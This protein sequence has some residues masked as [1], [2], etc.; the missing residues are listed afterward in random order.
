MKNY[1]RQDQQDF[2][3]LMFSLFP[4]KRVKGNPLS[5][6]YKICSQ[7]A[8]ILFAFLQKKQKILPIL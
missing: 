1:F 8:M 5:L 4:G 6:G 7:R 3:D 2:S